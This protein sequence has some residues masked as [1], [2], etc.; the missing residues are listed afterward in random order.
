MWSMPEV[1]PAG[2]VVTVAVVASAAIGP[3]V[4]AAAVA[5]TVARAP[6]RN[7]RRVGDMSDLREDV[8]AEAVHAGGCGVPE[9]VEA[10]QV[11]DRAEQPVVV[12]RGVVQRVGGDPSGQHDGPNPAAAHAADAGQR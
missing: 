2:G 6:A 11:L 10:E 5:P 1:A 9:V 7:W 3:N 4:E 12:V 8:A